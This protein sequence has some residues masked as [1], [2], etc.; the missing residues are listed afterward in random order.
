[1]SRRVW[2]AAFCLPWFGLV[3]LFTWWLTF[4]STAIA[5][6]LAAEV[7]TW[8]AG[9]FILEMDDVGPWWLGLAA[10]D[11]KMYQYDARKPDEPSTLMLAAED[12]RVRVGLFGLFRR[13]LSLSG[14][15]TAGDTTVDGAWVVQFD[16]GRTKG[17]TT[18]SLR[19]ESLGARLEDLGLIAPLPVVATGAV[20]VL[21]DVAGE[22]GMRTA[23]GTM[24]IGGKGLAITELA[25]EGLEGMDLGMEI[26]IDTLDLQLDIKDGRA[27]FTKGEIS[28]AMFDADIT[29]DI[30]L[31][32][33]ATRS[34]LR[35]NAVVELRGDL[36]KFAG[37]AGDAK[38]ADGKLHYVC[39]GYVS[40]PACRADRETTR[41]SA[42]ASA[43]APTVPGG[44]AVSSE[45]DD[46]RARRRE[47]A[48]ERV[49]RR[50]EEREG[51]G[52]TAVPAGDE[53]PVPA[54]EEDEP[55]I[56]DEPA[57]E[58]PPPEEVPLEE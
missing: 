39:T 5:S 20:D 28:G 44:G 34:H 3:Y 25:M 57:T 9:K 35:V 31:R 51:R 14:A 15:L 54:E 10:S 24:S 23:V 2:V 32:D 53:A 26:P 46:D 6:R 8:S 12:A 27:R 45:G 22:D 21:V 30:T 29:G 4:P 13:R 58:E 7:S 56:E 37:F 38:W 11:L 52:A 50:R 42:R 55:P 49:R 1:M 19:F 36:E 47:E 41:R 16:S 17:W 48:R 33:D 40:A 43:P 18:Q